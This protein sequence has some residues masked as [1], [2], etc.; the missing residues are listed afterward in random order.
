MVRSKGKKGAFLP[1]KN[2]GMGHAFFSIVREKSVL[3]L[4]KGVGPT[5]GRA[6]MLAAAELSTYDKVKVKLQRSPYFQEGLFTTLCTASVSGL[7][8]NIA[9]SPFDVVKS[10]VMGQPLNADGTGKL[11]TGMVDCFVKSAQTEGVISLCKGFWPNFGRVVPR[12][13]I[14]FIV[15]EN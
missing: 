9:S 11:Y 7:L 1:Q 14:V 2:N 3:G 10:R 8:S 13:V 15:M 5:V 4:W 6:T 12:V